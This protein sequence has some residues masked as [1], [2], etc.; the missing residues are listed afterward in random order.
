MM[1]LWNGS[2]LPYILATLFKPPGAVLSTYSIC[3]EYA[4]SCPRFSLEV[5]RILNHFANGGILIGV[6]EVMLR[7]KI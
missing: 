7:Q 2:M 6:D 3:A 5:L 1:Q 4:L